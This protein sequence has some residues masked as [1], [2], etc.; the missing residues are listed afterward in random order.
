MLSPTVPR[1]DPAHLSSLRLDDE[2]RSGSS[3]KELPHGLQ[4]SY[5]QRVLD[6]HILADGW[7]RG[8]AGP[9][10]CSVP[11][12]L[13]QHVA[14]EVTG[15]QLLLVLV[16]LQHVLV[17]FKGAQGRGREDEAALRHVGSQRKV[18]VFDVND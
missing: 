9:R 17:K 10:R 7:W 4:V 15:G 12:L 2:V 3:R 6:D 1:G 18:V 11:D 13:F 5:I 14:V 8:G 16:S